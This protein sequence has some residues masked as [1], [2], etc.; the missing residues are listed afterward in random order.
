[1]LIKGEEVNAIN[2]ESEPRAEIDLSIII[3]S[4]NSIAVLIPCLNSIYECR[5][6]LSFEI[7]LVDNGSKDNTVEEVRA[8]FEEVEIIELGANLGFAGANNI[9]FRHANGKY[10]LF[11]N[12]D[13]IMR[14]NVLEKLIVRAESDPDVAAVGPAIHGVDG[15]RQESAF[16][17]PSIGNSLATALWLY[18]IPGYVRMF[19][20]PNHYLE[21]DYNHEMEVDAVSGCCL[22]GRKAVLNEVGTFDDRYFLYFEEA[23]LCER[24][25]RSGKKIV[26]TPSAA[27]LHLGGTATIKHEIWS[28]IQ[29]EQ[30]QISFF[31]KNRGQVSTMVIRIIQVLQ[32]ILRI[33]VG[34]VIFCASGGHAKR[35]AKT[36]SYAYKLLLWE[37]RL[38]T[39]WTRPS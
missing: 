30:S 29:Y 22:L 7:I 15:K 28:R 19:G 38:S 36:V 27:I 20:F 17:A 18:R 6:C 4:F 24:I 25:R 32:S 12:P 13:T 21:D 3:V 10:V 33:T 1:M 37:L 31:A 8:R 9:G 5:P 2:R 39:H 26:Y 16:R 35:I 23:D 34:L 14:R 11:L